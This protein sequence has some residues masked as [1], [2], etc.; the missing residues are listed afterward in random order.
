MTL[1]DNRFSLGIDIGTSSVKIVVSD[2]NGKVVTILRKECAFESPLPG[3]AEIDPMQWV[4]AIRHM[5]NDLGDQMSKGIEVAGFD[6]QL[7][8]VVFTDADGV[9][10][11][12]AILWP[13]SRA[14][15]VVGRWGSLPPNVLARL[16]NP[17]V[18]GMYGPLLQWM[19]ELNAAASSRVRWALSPKDWVRGYFTENW[20][21]TDFSDASATLLWNIFLDDWDRDL[22]TTV[23]IPLD[24]LPEVR[25]A[26]DLVG[27][28]WNLVDGH[29]VQVCVGCGD[30]PA[31]ISGYESIDKGPDDGLLIIGS[32]I[33]FIE[34]G[35]FGHVGWPP[36]AHRYLDGR[37]R[38]Y[39]MS[40]VV[41]GGIALDRIRAVLGASWRE[42]YDAAALGSPTAGGPAVIPCFEP[43]RFGPLSAATFSVRARRP[44]V[45]EELLRSAVLGTCFVVRSVIEASARSM[46]GRTVVALG[47]GANRGFTSLLSQVLRCNF[48]IP[49]STE[50]TGQGIAGLA[51]QSVGVV[52]NRTVRIKERIEFRS[53]PVYEDEY[54][55]FS[56]LAIVSGAIGR[57]SEAN[58]W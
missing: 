57:T 38:P 22:A 30:V 56:N 10:V 34:S 6:G 49:D 3:W 41:N 54:Q 28:S 13:D 36:S 23:G 21:V 44:F 37:R 17:I 46:E 20:G 58:A 47:G 50:L 40:A 51:W 19:R 48:L 5:L 12:K 53:E 39:T 1:P 25:S 32:G 29:M 26:T 8:G 11:G 43:E 2:E 9:P 31:T 15:E 42:L 24:W 27:E 4:G 55:E 52:S 45:R 18:P 14:T 33:Q 35:E 16:G 7:H